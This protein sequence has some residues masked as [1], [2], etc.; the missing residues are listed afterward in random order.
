MK[1]NFAF[2][3][4]IEDIYGHSVAISA[5]EVS[6]LSPGSKPVGPPLLYWKKN[7]QTQLDFD[8]FVIKTGR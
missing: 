6:N 2:S 8:N 4:N 5:G 7:I 1:K 3:E